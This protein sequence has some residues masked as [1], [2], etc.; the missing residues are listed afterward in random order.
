M[1]SWPTSNSYAAQDSPSSRVIVFAV[2]LNTPVT[3]SFAAPPPWT[4]VSPPWAVTPPVVTPLS[5]STGPGVGVPAIVSVSLPWPSRTLTVS[6]VVRLALVRKVLPPSTL[7]NEPQ[8]MPP[9]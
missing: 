7:V 2:E 3:D 6:K 1:I 8:V 9:G 5:S 4:S